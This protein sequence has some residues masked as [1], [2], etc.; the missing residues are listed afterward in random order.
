MPGAARPP[1][2]SVQPDD[3]NEARYIALGVLV[4]LREDSLPPDDAYAWARILWH[5]FKVPR[6]H[7]DEEGPTLCPQ[8]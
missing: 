4:R 5:E 2:V 1:G 7:D 8:P 6:P 3:L